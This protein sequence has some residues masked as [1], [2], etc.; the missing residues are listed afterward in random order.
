MIIT[1]AEVTILS[2][3]QICLDVEHVLVRHERR[4]HIVIEF[5]VSTVLPVSKK[6]YKACARPQ[7]GPVT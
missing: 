3:Q 5:P 7:I 4:F 1:T 6:H 2:S